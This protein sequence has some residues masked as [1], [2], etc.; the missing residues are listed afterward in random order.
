MPCRE[1]LTILEARPEG[2]AESGART[3]LERYGPNRLPST[4]GPS[5]A[6]ILLKQVATPLMYALLASAV[7][8]IAIGEI[9]DGA[10]VLAVVVLNALI[11]TGQEFRAGRAIAALTELVAEPARVRRDGVWRELPAERV[12]RGDLLR[13]SQGERIAADVR[14]LR[15]DGLRTLEA[16]LTGESTPVDKGADPVPETAP[17]A[18]RSSS[19]GSARA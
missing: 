16:S 4:G 12:V 9:E 11:G 3:R 17:L 6:A 19:T 8:A 13:L 7:L 15:A 14:L 2:L 10:V 18:E 5:L 1:V